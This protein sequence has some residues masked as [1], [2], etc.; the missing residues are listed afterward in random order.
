MLH[1]KNKWGTVAFQA[2]GERKAYCVNQE[3][4]DHGIQRFM[5]Q[6]ESKL[7]S[8]YRKCGVRPQG[9]KGSQV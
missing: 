8:V 2:R 6:V 3:V 9:V 1:E 5:C 7:T 4:F